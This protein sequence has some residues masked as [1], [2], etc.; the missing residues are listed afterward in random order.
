MRAFLVVVAALYLAGCQV[1]SAPGPLGSNGP[2][3]GVRAGLKTP[4]VIAVD[5]TDERLVY[6][7]MNARGSSSP[8]YLSGG[9][10]LYATA[11]AANG[12]VVTIASYKPPELLSYDVTTR[13]KSI[14]VDPYGAPVDVA[15]GKTATLYALDEKNVGVFP[16]GSSSYKLSCR[17]IHIG[18]AIAVDNEGDVFVDGYGPGNSSGVVEYAAGSSTC[19]KLKLKKQSGYRVGLGVDPKT[20]DLIV[21]DWVGCAG[22]SEGRI[23][24]Y[25]RPYGPKV[26]ARNYLHGN[27]LGGFRL[28]ATSTNLLVLDGYSGARGDREVKACGLRWIDQ[29]SYPQTKGRSMYTNGCAAAVTTIP[30][31]LPN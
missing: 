27:C 13:K 5:A 14:I 23:T 22:G 11:M 17:Y 30:N 7:P 31:T 19:V 24:V 15:I 6:W 25:A 29:R 28:D 3:T 2:A 12:N 4:V 10:H 21:E 9:L 8:A 18:S 20:D 16:P 1:P 26:V